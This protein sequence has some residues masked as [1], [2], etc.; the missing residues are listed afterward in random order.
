M[1]KRVIPLPNNKILALSKSKAFAEDKLNDTKNIKFVLYRVEYVAWKKEL[2]LVSSSHN[3]F[4]GLF[5]Q[6]HQNA[7]QCRAY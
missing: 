6:G 4:R 3:V 2:M 1:S 5:L 7:P